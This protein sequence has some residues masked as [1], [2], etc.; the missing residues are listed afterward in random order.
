MPQSAR[1]TSPKP[2][3]RSSGRKGGTR[4]SSRVVELPAPSRLP[5]VSV[6]EAERALMALNHTVPAPLDQSAFVG[7]SLM[8]EQLRPRLVPQLTTLPEEL[9]LCIVETA[10][11]DSIVAAKPLERLAPLAA[12]CRALR[13][14]GSERA[15]EH[16]ARSIYPATSLRVAHA[17]PA[18]HIEPLWK[19]LSSL[20]TQL[21]RR[22]TAAVKTAGAAPATSTLG[23]I[24][25]DPDVGEGATDTPSLQLP[26]PSVYASWRRCL[27]HD[28][29]NGG[30]WAVNVHGIA[31]R[32]AG[33]DGAYCEARLQ[34]VALDLHDGLAEL[35]VLFDAAGDAT[36]LCE[37]MLHR[38]TLD[39]HRHSWAS[40]VYR[41]LGAPGAYLPGLH[42]CPP[43]SSL[44]EAS[45]LPATVP[46]GARCAD[47]CLLVSAHLHAAPPVRAG[48]GRQIVEM[49]FPAEILLDLSR[50]HD[51]P[52]AVDAWH[53]PARAHGARAAD[54]AATASAATAAG[55]DA[56]PWRFSLW[57]LK[58]KGLQMG[59]RLARS[60]AELAR[61]FRRAGT[62][63]E[64][65]LEYDA[66]GRGPR[67]WDV[68][69]EL[70]PRLHM[71]R[72]ITWASLDGHGAGDG[73]GAPADALGDAS[74]RPMLREAWSE[75]MGTERAANAAPVYGRAAEA[76][77]EAASGSDAPHGPQHGAAARWPSDRRFRCQAGWERLDQPASVR[78]GSEAKLQANW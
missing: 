60:T 27:A 68:P 45:G 6:E 3:R 23:D 30:V 50:D 32:H 2:A 61:L 13:F 19:G 25:E 4:I 57:D 7:L 33:R 48:P 10:F 74:W 28:N 71:N 35:I 24:A 54:G 51:G 11:R 20:V 70:L 62:F 17:A 67:A 29:A 64:L 16:L 18:G 44:G 58:F 49:T 56:T 76:D 38:A 65:P 26:R 39:H 59:S 63:C 55:R 15:A 69:C 77:A 5:T 53:E 31:C 41:L 40:P 43:P 75:H 8:V 72:G 12:T 22:R 52:F 9:L 66:D 78:E 42:P 37:H 73:S 14:I 1:H 34:S 36:M 21:R 47:S 46:A